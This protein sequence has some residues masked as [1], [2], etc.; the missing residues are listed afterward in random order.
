LEDFN[1]K[2]S[3][4]YKKVYNLEKAS[5]QE[6]DLA[7]NCDY[8]KDPKWVADIVFSFFKKKFPSEIQ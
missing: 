8:V 4:F 3:Y 7:I 6:F 5:T 1:L 2:Q